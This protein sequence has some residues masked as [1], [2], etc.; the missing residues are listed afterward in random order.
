MTIQVLGDSN[1]LYVPA[2]LID[3]YKS[4]VLKHAHTLTPN[5][6]EAQLLS[7]IQITS[8]FEAL[9]SATHS[10]SSTCGY[11]PPH[12]LTKLRVFSYRAA[13]CLHEMGPK[14]VVITSYALDEIGRATV[15]ERVGQYM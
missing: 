9:R 8:D 14:L 10:Y 6:F 4:D 3:I 11:A 2:S 12:P 15:R 5:W 1:K 7:D 13:I